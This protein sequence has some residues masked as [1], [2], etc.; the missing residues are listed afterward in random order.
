VGINTSALIES[1]IVG[2]L[3]Y[4]IRDAEFAGT[5]EGTLH[6][7]HLKNLGLLRLADTLEAHTAQLVRS[8]DSVERDREQIRGFVESFVRPRGL[9]QAATPLVVAAIEA[10]AQP[11]GAGAGTGAAA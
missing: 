3:V 9:D 11:Q 5:Q 1:G 8:F 10:A 7:Q 2:R 4:S 6:F